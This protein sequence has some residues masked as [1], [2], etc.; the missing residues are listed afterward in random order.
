ME[1][2]AAKLEF[3]AGYDRKAAEREA[4]IRVMRA[5]EIREQGELFDYK[6]G[7]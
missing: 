5:L 2:H 1:E 7:E 4:V 3:D 6:Q